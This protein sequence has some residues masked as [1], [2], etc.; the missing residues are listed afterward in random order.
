MD[1]ERMNSESPGVSIVS[2]V[3]QVIV[4]LVLVIAAILL[5]LGIVLL[6]DYNR[7]DEGLYLIVISILLVFLYSVPYFAFEELIKLFVRIEFNTRKDH[8]SERFSQYDSQSNKP[9]STS[10]IKND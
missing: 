6:T 7:S 1:S 10:P 5:I 3:L 2:V 8:H 9:R 4:I